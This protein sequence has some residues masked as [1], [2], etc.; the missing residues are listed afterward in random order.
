MGKKCENCGVN[1][2][3]GDRDVCEECIQKVL[4]EG[5]F[6]NKK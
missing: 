6:K 4:K 2:V 3:S 1:E 5:S